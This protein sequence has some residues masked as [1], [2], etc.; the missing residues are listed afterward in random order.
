MAD[1]LHN[2]DDGGRQDDEDRAQV[3]LRR[4]DGWQRQPRRTFNVRQIDNSRTECDDVAR[5]YAD[6]NRD[7]GEEAAERHRGKDGD[8]KGCD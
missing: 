3:E 6:E 8:G 5:D 4:V 7:D 2:D 1:V